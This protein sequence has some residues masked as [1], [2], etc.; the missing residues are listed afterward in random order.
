VGPVVGFFVGPDVGFHVG[1]TVGDLVG[2]IYGGAVGF[3][4]GFCV[5]GIVAEQTTTPTI[6]TMITFKKKD[7]IISID[8]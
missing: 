3:G 4:V 2:V 6:S 7:I 5:G 8:N 1:P